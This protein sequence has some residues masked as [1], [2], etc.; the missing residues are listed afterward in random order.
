MSV[1]FALKEN[2]MLQIDEA[3]FTID[4]ATVF[5]N[6]VGLTA[7]NRHE[8]LIYLQ[9]D[10][11]EEDFAELEIKPENEL[12]LDEIFELLREKQT[13][14]E[15]VQEDRSEWIT[16]ENIE[17]FMPTKEQLEKLASLDNAIVNENGKR[18]AGQFDDCEEH[19][20]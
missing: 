5:Y 15:E 12:L 13:A 6:N 14:L 10:S 18:V 16:A 11:G 9:I 17:E 8:S 4:S 1:K 7:L 20:R 2:K 3:S 19:Q